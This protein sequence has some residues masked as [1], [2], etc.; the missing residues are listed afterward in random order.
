MNPGIAAN[1]AAIDAQ[2]QVSRGAFTLDVDLRADPGTV[3]AVL[4]PNGA[5]KTTLL[6]VLAGLQQ[7]EHGSVRLA[8]R[9]VDSGSTTSGSAVF[10]PAR[11]RAAGVVFQDYLLFPHLTVLQNV[12][13]GPRARRLA[14]PE[15]LARQALHRLGIDALADRRPATLSGGQAQRVALARALAIGPQ[16]LLLDEPLAALDVQVRD[17]VR[18][19]L[20]TT[21]RDF[22]GATVLVTHDPQDAFALADQVVVIEEGR[23]TQVGSTASLVHQPM[24]AYVAALTGIN[25]IQLPVTL[26]DGRHL[27]FTGP[28][29]ATD[30]VIDP[31]H[32]RVHRTR[33]EL[34]G[35]GDTDDN[36]WA[37]VVHAVVGQ[38]DGARIALQGVPEVVARVSAAEL[39]DLRPVA[40][41]TVWV[42]VATDAV[43]AW[44]AEA[45]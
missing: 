43:R 2:I 6:R 24:T 34:A 25:R 4:G 11:E 19:E 13:F 44:R 35:A 30:A 15:E 26:V 37:A 31:R 18:A 28:A 27:R 14:A 20:A 40:G 9:V 1:G 12:A 29:D 42:S 3:V 5:G 17:S 23:V 7:V 41:M 21:L 38:P 8:G 36:L 45:S 22:P 39:V 32:I 16:V 33:P 10:V